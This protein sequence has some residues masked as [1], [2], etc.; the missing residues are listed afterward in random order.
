MIFYLKIIFF[1]GVIVKYRLRKNWIYDIILIFLI[2]DEDNVDGLCGNFNN[3]MFD[4]FGFK[5]FFIEK[6]VNF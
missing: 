5:K 4:E 6:V 2:F 1:N 3:D